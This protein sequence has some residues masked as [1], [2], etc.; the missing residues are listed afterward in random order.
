MW[1]ALLGALLGGV[2]TASG[3]ALVGRT[4]SKRERQYKHYDLQ[5][6]AATE[7]VS[8]LQNLNRKIIDLA[9]VQ[10]GP[11]QE[12]WR[13]AYD[14]AAVRWNAARFAAT[15]VSSAAAITLMDQLDREVDELFE[16]ASARKWNS[17]DFRGERVK[18][19][20]TAAAYQAQVRADTGQERVVLHSI[21]VWDTP[22]LAPNS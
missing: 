11:T 17:S 20:R 12:L 15:L 21:W 2:L 4:L 9:R 8:A 5:L 22:V 14:E 7:V 10:P 13:A 16:S 6:V 3:S 18:I 1:A 19:G